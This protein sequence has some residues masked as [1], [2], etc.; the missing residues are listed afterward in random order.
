MT[1]AAP[2]I[3]PL[4]SAVTTARYG[5]S[6]PMRSA[7]SPRWNLCRVALAEA[8]KRM[9]YPQRWLIAGRTNAVWVPNGREL[10]VV[11]AH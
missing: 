10:A 4:L 8:F 3:V 7:G 11:D 2:Q 5:F 9:S 1:D 6:P